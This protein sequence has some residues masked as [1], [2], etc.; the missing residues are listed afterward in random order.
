MFHPLKKFTYI[1]NNSAL[2]DF[3][4]SKFSIFLQNHIEKKWYNLNLV[5]FFE[6]S[7]GLTIS[8]VLLKLI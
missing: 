6:I 7:S 8:K 5:F 2:I 1:I 3:I 4:R